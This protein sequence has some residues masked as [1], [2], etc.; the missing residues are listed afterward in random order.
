MRGKHG[1]GG[2]GW[3]EERTRGG[4]GQEHGAAEGGG[5]GPWGPGQAKEQCLPATRLEPEALEG[6]GCRTPCGDG[7]GKALELQIGG[8]SEV[9]G[10]VDTGVGSL[11]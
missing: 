4:R 5:G 1:G 6:T 10:A 8:V 7:Q 3:K 9:V 2:G 11:G